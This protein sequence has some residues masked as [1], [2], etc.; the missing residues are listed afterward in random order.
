MK[1]KSL[2]LNAGVKLISDFH[3]TLSAYN[4]AHSG[5]DG[6][7][8]QFEIAT[9]ERLF[10]MLGE[11][12][13]VSLR[14]TSD[15]AVLGQLCAHYGTNAPGVLENP[16]SAPVRLMFGKKSKRGKLE[17]ARSAW[18]YGKAFRAAQT[19][20]WK[21]GD[22]AT[23]VAGFSL[24]VA[25]GGKDKTLRFLSALEALDR[26]Q[27]GDPS[28]AWDEEES[29]AAIAWL[30]RTQAP[31]AT[32]CG[33]LATDPRDRQMLGLVAQY[34]AK[35]GEWQV[36]GVNQSD[37]ARAWSTIAKPMVQ[38]FREWRSEAA[39]KLAVANLDKHG[40]DDIESL[41]A[42]LAA[43]GDYIGAREAERQLSRRLTVFER[44]GDFSFPREVQVA[45]DAITSSDESQVGAAA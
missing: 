6:H 19:L 31:L 25:A 24:V 2:H 44:D 37:S 16:H 42:A 15:M 14:L 36:R 13:S 45:G 22:F 18:K 33:T 4:S 11:A 3:N 39:M 38:Q 21:A 35:T 5:K 1:N 28:A 41:L 7:K 20:G 26:Q 30:A 29:R 12:Y 23:N 27:N 8:E 34:D 32:F 17:A 40:P 9:R 10:E 43:Q